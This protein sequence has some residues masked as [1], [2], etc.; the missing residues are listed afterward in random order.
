MKVHFSVFP[1]PLQFLPLSFPGPAR[2]ESGFVAFRFGMFG[3]RQLGKSRHEILK[4]QQ[5]TT[6]S[7]VESGLEVASRSSVPWNYD[8]PRSLC[9]STFL[10]SRFGLSCRPLSHIRRRPEP[11]DRD[12]NPE[13]RLLALRRNFVSENPDFGL[14]T[15]TLTYSHSLTPSPTRLSLISYSGLVAVHFQWRWRWS[16]EIGRARESDATGAETCKTK[17]KCFHSE[18]PLRQEIASQIDSLRNYISWLNLLE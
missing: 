9:C 2:W 6:E 1:F 16:E 12:A 13:G 14:D 7:T 17:G 11:R 8:I 15:H 3:K 18:P 5:K 4:G 10:S